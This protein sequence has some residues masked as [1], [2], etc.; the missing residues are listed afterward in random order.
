LAKVKVLDNFVGHD[1]IRFNLIV[2]YNYSKVFT[3]LGPFTKS[4]FLV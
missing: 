1:F 2:I 4:S 3:T